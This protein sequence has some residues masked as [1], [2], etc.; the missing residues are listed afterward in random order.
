MKAE[1]LIYLPLGGAG[2]IGMNAYVFGYG[3][4]EKERLILVDLGVGF[5]DMETTPGVDLIFPDIFWLVQRKDRLEGIFFTHAHEDHVG[6]VA[7]LWDQLQAPLYARNF[8]SEILKRKMRENGHNEDH[9]H[10]IDA[11]PEKVN[12]GPFDVQFLPVSHSIPESSALV[13]NTPEG[14]L[15]HTG[16]FKLDRNPGVGEPFDDDLW[17]SVGQSGVKA[18]FCDSTNVFS[19]KPGRSE[20]TIGQDIEE[21]IA[22]HKGLICATTFASNIARV[23][24]LASAGQRAGR[25]IVLLGGAMKRMVE[26]AVKTG[27]LT[28]FPPLVSPEDAGAI[29]R[30]NLMLL[31]TGSQGER[32]AASAQLA[33][34]KFYGMEL[35]KGD[36]F[37]FSSKTIP[38]NEKGVARIINALSEKHVD[39]VDD[40]SGRYHVS[41][42]ANRPDLVE[43][44]EIINP[45]MVIPLHG[46]HRHLREHCALAK[47][48][49]RAAAVV[50]NGVIIDLT[51]ETPFEI[52][53]IGAGR[54]YKDGSVL[55]GSHDGVVLARI[56]TALN[57][58]VFVSLILDEDDEIIGDPWCEIVGLSEMGL[59]Q[60]PLVD[61]LEED[62]SQMLGR[63][64][65][66]DRSDDDALEKAMR[67]QIH[68]T[69]KSEIGRRPEVLVIIS[70]MG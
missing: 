46:E 62:L 69:C 13:I 47:E 26:T 63:L 24:T 4:P 64:P 10:V 2:E 17:K 11:F 32:R 6:A 35:K 65:D 60:A 67:K 51:G 43:M 9:V 59:S 52:D 1:R 21:L 36:L 40:S 30:E 19:P 49:G 61:I 16:D 31:V 25:S 8:T 28:D 56:R 42:H 3:P 33:R 27:V 15:L 5:P 29:A 58:H 7:H 41:G 70:R 68:H 37:L 20:S 48:H 57:G 66:Q 18:L 23:K 55:V 14:R 38:G 39:V 54:I 22:S 45:K 34:G 44:H 53:D 50:K 12:A